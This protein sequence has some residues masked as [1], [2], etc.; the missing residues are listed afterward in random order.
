MIYVLIINLKQDYKEEKMLLSFNWLKHYVDINDINPY[1]LADKMTLAGIEVEKVYRLSNA[2]NCVVGKVLEKIKHEKADKLSVCNVDLGNE[3]A[4]IVC[5]AKNVAKGQKVVVAKNGATLPSGIKIKKTKLRGVESNGMICSLKELGVENKLVPQEFQ[6]GIVVLDDDAIVGK[7]AIKYLGLN[8]TILELDLTPNR[9]DCLSMNGIAYEVGAILDKSVNLP[10]GNHVAYTIDRDFTVR[11]D[12][13]N[14]LLYYA[15]KIKGVK[16]K[17][18]PQWLQSLLIACGIRPINNVVDVTNFVMLELGQPLHAF[19]LNKLD[20]EEILVRDA[21]K[22]EFI[23]TLDDIKRDL[24]ET[25]LLITDAKKPIALAGVMGG[26]NTEIDNNTV[27]VLLESAVFEPLTVRNTYSRLN[28]R[29]ESSLRYEKGVDPNRALYALIRAAKLL[30]DLAVG[31]IDDKIAVAKNYEVKDNKIN[32]TLNKINKTLGINLSDKEVIDVFRRLKF[33]FNLFK[34]TFTVEVPSRR[35][36]IT[37]QEDLIEEII[38]IHGYE[39]L[40]NT[41]PLTTTIGELTPKQKK[42]RLVRNTLIACGLDDVITYSLTSEK[43]NN[44]YQYDRDISQ[45][46]KLLKPMSEERAVMR[47]GI[48]NN[49]LE[50]LSYNNARNIE[51]ILLFEI[52]N[53][54]SIENNETKETILLS[55]A[56]MGVVSETKWQKKEENVDF[57]FVKGVLETVFDKLSILDR[58]SFVQNTKCSKDFHPMRTAN[59]LLEDKVIGIIGQ[60]HPKRQSHFDLKDT[61]VFELDLESL[62]NIENKEKRYTIISKYP[63]VTRDIAIIVDENITSDNIVKVIRESGKKILKN[64]EVFDII[65]RAHV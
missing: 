16:I 21:Y 44:L 1:E 39:N 49:L 61:F 20:N 41:L 62:L 37:I 60:I 31:E 65:G 19:D 51:N 5:G 18:S 47:Q 13:D 52:G 22:D 32:I 40:K 4:Q 3:V 64:I 12:S 43:N 38:R 34:D 9:S 17:K 10:Y 15:K 55:G 53:R 26:K 28:L 54:Y 48:I 36:D 29:S 27:D 11:I 6:D 35:R 58:I 50:V 45:S 24:L 42:I 7:D 56:C 33:N 8:D 2:K 23:I 30:E 57:Y 59:I 46:V 14:C 25:D 63:S